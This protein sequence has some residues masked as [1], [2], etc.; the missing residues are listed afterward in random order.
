V[1]YSINPLQA[2]FLIV[3]INNKEKMKEHFKQPIQTEMITPR[4]SN[5][6]SME[7]VWRS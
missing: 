5:I 6:Y 2:D 1:F 7:Q 4:H 3:N